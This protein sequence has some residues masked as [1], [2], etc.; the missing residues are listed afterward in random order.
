MCYIYVPSHAY[1]DLRKKF[2]RKWF[3]RIPVKCVKN[4]SVGLRLT[5][6]EELQTNNDKRHLQLLC[7]ITREDIQQIHLSK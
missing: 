1:I 5:D 6:I 7:F 3:L 2:N 4:T